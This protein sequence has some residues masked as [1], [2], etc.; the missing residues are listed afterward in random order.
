M[1]AFH[2]LQ[3]NAKGDQSD[4]TT[5]IHIELI[6][7]TMETQSTVLITLNLPFPLGLRSVHGSGCRPPP[8]R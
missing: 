2:S 3:F 8:G 5:E 6:K 1:V 7:S 4:S